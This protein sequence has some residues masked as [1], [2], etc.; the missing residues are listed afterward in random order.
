MPFEKISGG[1]IK[2]LLKVTNNKKG[3]QNNE[4]VF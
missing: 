2:S 4:D 3:G 1:T